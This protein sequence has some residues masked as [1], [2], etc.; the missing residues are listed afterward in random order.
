M[1][2]VC[3]TGCCAGTSSMRTPVRSNDRRSLGH[4]RRARGRRARDHGGAWPAP[5][6]IVDDD[7]PHGG[8][9][10]RDTLVGPSTLDAW[11]V[12][13]A[14]GACRPLADETPKSM[15]TTAGRP[16]LERFVLV[17]HPFRHHVP[18]DVVQASGPCL[19]RLVEKPVTS[20]F[21]DT[22]IHMRE[23]GLIAWISI[24]SRIRS[25]ICSR[26]VSGAATG[27]RVGDCQLAGHWPGLRARPRPRPA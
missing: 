21:I 24:D 22:G 18:Y 12:I 25:P 19:S 4:H 11:A 27:R 5:V 1:I 14:G 7:G 6:P 15:L 13:M 20:W 3:W 2:V 8:A 17:V 23:P 16:I 26:R 10:P 9:H